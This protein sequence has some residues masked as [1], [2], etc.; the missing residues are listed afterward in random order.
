ME[1][2]I[3]ELLRGVTIG[4]IQSVGYMQVIPLISELIDNK[5][6]SP[7]NALVSTSNY[8]TLVVKNRPDNGNAGTMILPFGAGYVVPQA[9]QDHATP[10][11]KIIAAN[12]TATIDTAACIQQTQGGTIASSKQE[13]TILPWAIKEAVFNTKNQQGYSKLWP[14]IGEFNQSLGLSDKGHLEFFLKNFRQDLDEFIGQFEIVHNQVG[15][16]VLMNGYVVG[17]ERTPNYNYWKEVWKPLIR[18]CYGSLAIQ[19]AK[20]FGDS[21]PPPRTRVPL[22]EANI[23]TAEDLQKALEKATQK[24]AE[25]VKGIVRR[26]V[27]TKFNSQEE[28][29]EEDMRVDSI[30]NKQ[31]AGQVVFDGEKPVYLSLFTN[32]AWLKDGDWHEADEFKI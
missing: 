23:N 10:L 30:S 18:E 28:Q 8:G 22:S 26:F 16:I 5:F 15:A 2:T 4:R 11:A 14:A 9:A 1:I 3:T 25:N 7:K 6:I 27:K 24:E 17:I 12:R 20:K 19:Y 29:T 31:F 32:G 21:P 13:M